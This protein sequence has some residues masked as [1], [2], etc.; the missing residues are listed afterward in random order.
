ML[1]KIKSEKEEE[2]E[3]EEEYKEIGQEKEEEKEEEYLYK[4]IGEKDF[5]KKFINNFG[6]IDHRFFDGQIHKFCCEESKAEQNFNPNLI[7]LQFLLFYF[8][9]IFFSSSLFNKSENNSSAFIQTSF[10]V[11]SSY[12]VTLPSKLLRISENL[13]L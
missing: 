2:K 3:E 9:S 12:I 8:S 4:S 10:S 5:R 11:D 6:F 7:N 13:F 1:K